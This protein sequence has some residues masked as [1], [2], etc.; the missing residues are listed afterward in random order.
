KLSSPAASVR[1]VGQQKGTSRSHIGKRR[2]CLRRD[3]EFAPLID[4]R[5]QGNNCN[6]CGRNEGKCP[7]KTRS[8]IEWTFTQ[9]FRYLSAATELEA[10]RTEIVAGLIRETVRNDNRQSTGIHKS[11]GSIDWTIYFRIRPTRSHRRH[12]GHARFG[13]KDAVPAELQ[14]CDA[15]RSSRH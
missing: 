9:E 2:N 5:P 8:D 11:D 1:K 4:Q 10:V 7:R 15:R 13:D 12:C 3:D 14:D 6:G